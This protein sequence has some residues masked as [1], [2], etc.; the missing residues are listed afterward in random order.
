MH[1]LQDIKYF[2][3]TKLLLVVLI[4]KILKTERRHNIMY[5]LYLYRLGSM[6]H[7]EDFILSAFLT[8][9]YW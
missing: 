5:L 9:Q 1:F 4:I 2:L 7:F 6:D 3:H 8:I